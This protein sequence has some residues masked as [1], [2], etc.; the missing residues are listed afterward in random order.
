MR[1]MLVGSRGAVGEDGIPRQFDYSV[2]IGE[3][4]M[5][6]SFACESYGAKIAERGGDSR[7]VPNITVRAERIQELMETLMTHTVAPASL[8]D[9][10]E[11]WL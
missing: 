5:G 4:A 6:G 3:M 2:V 11:D 9:V 1:E 10:V 7:T 8:Q